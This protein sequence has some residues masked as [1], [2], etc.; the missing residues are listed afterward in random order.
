MDVEFYEFMEMTKDFIR[1]EMKILNRRALTSV[2][3]SNLIAT[4]LDKFYKKYAGKYP[5]FDVSPKFPK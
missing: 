2:E 4:S 5:E 1:M 3:E